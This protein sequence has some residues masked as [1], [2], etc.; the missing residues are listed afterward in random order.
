MLGGG[1]VGLSAAVAFARA[2]PGVSVTVVASDLD[3]AALADTMP[4]TL[5]AIAGFH[6]R[7]GVSE[8]EAVAAGATHR[9]G[10]RFEGWG[11]DHKPFFHAF[12]EAGASV[13][14]GPFHQHWL[15]ARRGGRAAGFD[16]H[17]PAAALAR[18]GK[19]V[20][21]SD[22][23]ASPLSH[24]EYAL[25]LDPPRYR[26][27]LLAH[28]RRLA[29]ALIPG[30][31]AGVRHREDGGVAAIALHGGREVAADLFLD[32]AGPSAPL[33]SALGDGFE[34]WSDVLPCDRLR[35]AEAPARPPSSCDEVVA[36]PAGWR[37]ASPGRDRTLTGFCYTAAVT[38]EASA[39]RIFAGAGEPIMLRPGFRTDPWLGNVL[40]LGD[41]AVAL[42][43]LEWT[44]L[45]LAQSGIA[46]ALDLLS[47]RD[48]HPL[49]IAEYNRRTRQQAERARDFIAAHY[50]AA[51]RTRGDFW[52]AAARLARPDSLA[53]TLEQFESRGRL[54]HCEEESFTRDSWLAV[55]LGL[56]IVPRRADPVTLGA[57][58][59]AVH[60]ALGR[61]VDRVAALPG[62][63]PSYPDYLARI[64]AG[65]R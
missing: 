13:A 29:V 61:I 22:D 21:P 53:H 56:G 5:P 64:E 31:L 26:A 43:P 52:R 23:P 63:L 27:L 9:V 60:A 59:A 16:S 39:A 51:G 58:P 41:A 38:R 11:G 55:L 12:G 35:L 17:S 44:N 10:T 1:I 49:E 30:G 28:A 54:P 34:D 32:C 4:G 14:P 24:F 50:A 18:A 37:W 46:R 57:D 42:D 3:P 19:F 7:I 48:C 62:A 25:R 33:R 6:D 47:G 45:H 15:N 65:R 8:D 2:L 36:M 20:P 40:A